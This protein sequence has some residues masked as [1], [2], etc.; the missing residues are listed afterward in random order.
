MGYIAREM[1]Y[2]ERKRQK[3]TGHYAGRKYGGSQD[4]GGS[5]NNPSYS[6]GRDQED[7]GLKPA[8]ANSS[9]DPVSKKYKKRAGGV[10]QGIIPEFKPQ[11]L[12][13]S[14]CITKKKKKKNLNSP[15]SFAAMD[16]HMTQL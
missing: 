10:A 13:S 7:H 2:R 9:R 1:E 3:T 8:W 15:P 16:R 5:C 11:A 4:A 6:G 14:P 12:S